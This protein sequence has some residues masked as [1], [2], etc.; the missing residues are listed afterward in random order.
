MNC[1]MF[2]MPE[3]VTVQVTYSCQ[4][5][6][7]RRLSKTR[8]HQYFLKRYKNYGGPGGVNNILQ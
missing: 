2:R 1:Q 3:F 4:K 7:V 6:P 8:I 5:Q